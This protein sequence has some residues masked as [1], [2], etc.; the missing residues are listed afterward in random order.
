VGLSTAYSHTYR[1]N[2]P[3]EGTF[4]VDDNF[5]VPTAFSDP[6]GDLPGFLVEDHILRITRNKSSH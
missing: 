1:K 5:P 3:V 2:L 4:V 6:V